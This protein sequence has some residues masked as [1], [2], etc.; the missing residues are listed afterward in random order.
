M[1]LLGR[2]CIKTDHIN[3]KNDRVKRRKQANNASTNGD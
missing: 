1:V 2:Y 3:I